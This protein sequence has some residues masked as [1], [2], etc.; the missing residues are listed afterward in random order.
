MLIGIT[1]RAGAGKDTVGR[2]LRDSYAVALTSFAAPMKQ[3]ICT[4]LNVEYE[5]WEDREWKEAT[6][7]GVNYSPRQLAQTLGTEWGRNTLDEDFWVRM[8]LKHAEHAQAQLPNWDVAFTDCRF[9]NEAAAIRSR[10][11]M[12]WHI[13]RPGDDD[14][15]KSQH[16]SEAGIK[17]VPSTDF[18]IE[19]SGTLRQLEGFVHSAYTS[20]ELRE[21]ANAAL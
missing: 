7:P 3:M 17:F 2:I 9:E 11:G 10:G 20:R 15:T 13:I 6:I 19:N 5:M 14:A 12:I 8:A 21:Q 18:A 4:L 1:G 16:A